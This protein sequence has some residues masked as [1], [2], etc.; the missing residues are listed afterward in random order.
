MANQAENTPLSGLLTGLVNDVSGLVRKEVQLAKTEASEQFDKALTGFE[1]LLFGAI[2]VIVAL[3]VLLS[4]L[5]SGLAAV[6]VQSG[7]SDPSANALSGGIV[8]VIFALAGW[9]LAS[10]G[11]KA[12][13]ARNLR[14]ERTVSSVRRDVGVVKEKI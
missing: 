2:L 3:G 13:R 12:M 7:M 10:R 11:L 5:V 1:T 6:F 14:M 8:G 4:A 9:M